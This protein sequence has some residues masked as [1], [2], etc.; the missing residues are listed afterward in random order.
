[1]DPFASSKTTVPS[2][3]MPKNPLSHCVRPRL[4]RIE[5][6]RRFC[7]RDGTPD[8]LKGCPGILWKALF[9]TEERTA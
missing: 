2:V 6:T 4:Y 9:R 7:S 3:G 8:P 1:M 5:A